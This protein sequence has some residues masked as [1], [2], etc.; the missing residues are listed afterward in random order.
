MFKKCRKNYKDLKNIAYYL[1]ILIISGTDD[2]V[3][4]QKGVFKLFVKYGEAQKRVFLKAYLN[5]RHEL[6]NETN[7]EEVYNDV[8]DFM[9]ND[10][11]E[12]ISISVS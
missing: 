12:Y 10:K 2:E 11:I 7:K 8:A 6:L 4:G 1:A 9:T 3:S 5:A